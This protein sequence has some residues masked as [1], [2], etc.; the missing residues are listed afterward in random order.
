MNSPDGFDRVF[1]AL[2]ASRSYREA[3]R[4]AT[5]ELPEW[6]IPFNGIGFDELARIARETRA[7]ASDSFV[8]LACGTGGSGL[9][10]AERTGASLVGV[11]FSAAAIREAAKLARERGRAEQ[12]RFVVADAE[13]TGLTTAAFDAVVCIDALIFMKAERAANEIARLLRRGGYAVATS[14]EMLSDDVLLPSMVRDYAPIFDSAGL[15]I[16]THEVLTGWS[17]RLT[18]YYRALIER[19][20]A[21]REEMGEAASSLLEEARDGIAREGRPPR[22]RKVFIV[23]ERR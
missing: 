7:G 15:A 11:D 2:S 17:E 6:L 14:W 13:E 9:W 18:L 20:S 16:Q 1:A 19:E 10:I 21:L 22:V 4:A 3:T 8:D 12:A 5:P 23:A